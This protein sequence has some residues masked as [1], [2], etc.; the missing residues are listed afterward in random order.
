MLKTVE[1]V[2]PIS[3]R[4]NKTKLPPILIKPIVDIRKGLHE[5]AMSYLGE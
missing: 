1:V 2:E 4:A 5:E 3:T